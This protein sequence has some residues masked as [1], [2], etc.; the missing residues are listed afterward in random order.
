[1]QLLSTFARK[2]PLQS[3]L[4]VLAL[5]FAG[6][7]EGFGISIFIPLINLILNPEVVATAEVDSSSSQIELMLEDM[8]NDVLASFGLNHTI[9][10]LLAIFFLCILLKSFLL[11]LANRQVGYAVA[12]IATDLRLDLLRALF[13]SRWE[14][15]VRQPVGKLTNAIATEANR[16]ASA[17]M[18]SAKIVSAG[19][20]ALVFTTL[21][22]FVSWK[23]TLLS[24]VVGAI[25]LFGLRR[26][27]KKAKRAGKQQT[28][29]L[30]SLIAFMTDCLNSIKPLKAMGR[31]YASS[32]VLR[33]HTERLNRSL[34][35]QVLSKAML[36]ALQEP[37]VMA[38]IAL[39]LYAAL[40]HLEMSLVS[41]L[42]M[43]YLVRR[44][45]KNVQHIQEEYQKL[46]IYESAYWALEEK[47]KK[48]EGERETELGHET[49]EFKRCIRFKNI[50]FAYGQKNVLTD[51]SL[52]MPMGRFVSL[53]GPSG[54]G[55]TTIADLVTGLLRPQRG[56]IWIDDRP[57][58]AI[59]VAQWRNMIGYVP[60]EL[61]LLHDTILVNVTLGDR[62]FCEEDVKR[63]LIA[64]GAWEFV[65]KLKQGVHTI[66]GERGSKLSG[67]QRQRI[68]IARALVNDPK[69]L[70]LDEATTALDPE[71]ESAICRTL[72]ALRGRIAILAISHQSAMLEAAEIAY[73]L[74]NGAV[75]LIKDETIEGDRNPAQVDVITASP[76]KRRS[77]TA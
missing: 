28:K 40:I 72:I 12:N 25:I 4:T 16:A 8:L 51:V 9:A 32:E 11:M 10:G 59:D 22:F 3:L 47:I 56:D 53:I 70:I 41:I 43:V 48:S 76:P 7:A 65:S 27:V 29:L 49:P 46:V 23:G 17:F 66:V 54:A 67:G 38:F 20:E 24:F 73:R 57:L 13:A 2:Y 45:L 74:E 1:M 61:L 62:K 42:A 63:A 60:Q 52:E 50:N 36:K 33:T 26:Y 77:A 69:L 55:K 35:K 71:N 5:L 30:Q 37:I 64:A 18:L 14:Y 58:A 39:T 19:A 34:Q 15:F 68:A 6:V 44:V 75:K 21:A 31:E